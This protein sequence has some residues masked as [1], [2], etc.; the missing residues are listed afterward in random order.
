MTQPTAKGLEAGDAATFPHMQRTNIELLDELITIASRH[1]LTVPVLTTAST[2]VIVANVNP[3]CAFLL[4]NLQLFGRGITGTVTPYVYAVSDD[5]HFALPTSVPMGGTDAPV[6]GS[7]ATKFKMPAILTSIGGATVAKALTDEIVFSAAHVVRADK[8][9]APAGMTTAWGRIF[10]L[11]SNAGAYTTKVAMATQ[12]TPQI[13][14]SRAELPLNV[15]P[16]TNTIVVG[17]FDIAVTMPGS[18]ITNHTAN[19]TNVFA[20]ASTK[21]YLLYSGVWNDDLSGSLIVRDRVEFPMY[22][23]DL[24]FTANALVAGD[25]LKLAFTAPD[26]SYTDLAPRIGAETDR[27]VVLV[28]TAG[29]SSADGSALCHIQYRAYP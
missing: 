5:Y 13:N 6:V 16:D 3:G 11:L 10:I 12:T 14:L 29:A 7:T 28:V 21:A 9:T 4:E 18:G 26:W 24:A 1:L 27:I 19:T 15:T 23:A 2:S 25:P 8:D 17:F 22:N 20:N